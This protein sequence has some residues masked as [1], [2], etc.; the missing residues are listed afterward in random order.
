M[1]ITTIPWLTLF[2]PGSRLHL[3]SRLPS[4]FFGLTGFLGVPMMHQV[5]PPLGPSWIPV[6]GMLCLI[7]AWPA[8]FHP[9]DFSLSVPSQLT[10]QD[11]RRLNILLII[12]FI[13][14]YLFMAALGLRCCMRAFL[15]AARGI[16]HNM[17]HR[18]FQSGPQE[19]N[20]SAVLCVL[21]RVI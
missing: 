20:S 10:A 7:F 13:Y 3:T 21:L 8:S 11:L 14:F 6:S 19:V 18:L 1:T 17:R 16:D 9:S 5:F 4:L 2:Y 12:L 15:V